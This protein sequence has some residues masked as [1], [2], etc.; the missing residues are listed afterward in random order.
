MD[1][2]P[3]QK[4]LGAPVPLT[5]GKMGLFN[6]N[7]NGP[8]PYPMDDQPYANDTYPEPPPSLLRT[9]TDLSQASTFNSVNS[10]KKKGREALERKPEKPLYEI[11]KEDTEYMGMLLHQTQTIERRPYWNILAAALTWILLAGFIVLPGTYTNFQNSEI[12]QAAK[13][14]Q[15][16][17][18]NRILAQ[19]AAPGLLV[20]AAI[21][22]GIG[23]LGIIGLWYK[24]RKNYVWLINKLLLY[25]QKKHEATWLLTSA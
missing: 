23:T 13:D 3:Y 6:K 18:G 14:D 17:L 7:S 16:T 9:R 15:S 19:I 24:W 4:V 5:S 10:F 1:N 2:L 22:C 25:V 21:L 8:V 12:I 20:V 11:P